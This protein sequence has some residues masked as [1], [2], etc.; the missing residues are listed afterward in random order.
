MDSHQTVDNP[1]SR[2]ETARITMPPRTRSIVKQPASASVPAGEP[3]EA[4]AERPFFIARQPIFD[5]QRVVRAYELLFRGDSD[6]GGAHF[7]DG[8]AATAQL[9][10]QASEVGTFRSLSGGRPLFLNFTRDLLVNGSATLLSA[11][12][13]VVEI[14]EDVPAD[15]NVIERC[16]ELVAA[17]YRVALDDVIDRDRIEAFQD[18]ATIVK[19]DLMGTSHEQIEA[20]VPVARH[21]RQQLLAEKVETSDDLDFTTALGF[22]YFQGYFLS[23]PESVKR[24]ALPGLKPTHLKLLDV[25]NRPELDIDEVARTVEADP[26]LTYKLLRQANAPARALNRRIT[27]MR[28]VVVLFGQSEIRRAATF[29]VM[30]AIVGGSEHLLHQSV[31]LARF[32]DNVGRA[33][34][35][36]ATESFD[37]YL[38]GLLANIDALLGESMARAL[39][40]LP[41]S[42]L[43]VA[44]LTRNEGA[45]AHALAMGRAY[46][47]G[48]WAAVTAHRDA[49]GL[50]EADVSAVYLEAIESADSAM[51]A[52][53]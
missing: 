10:S 51:A 52:A 18:A 53:A 39:R 34:D 42:P 8:S 24:A 46:L 2:T 13:Y 22:D 31:T 6:T 37:F 20:I 21:Y 33:L 17:G 28:D 7:I 41:V 1:I 15:S 16:R 44:A 32:C 49:L 19:V 29:T 40:T 4:P 26:S 27:S 3:L 43:V 36:P 5:R 47:E 35:V 45:A 25:V 12:R 23:R 50:S 14:L 48:D 30:G 11:K 38:V 9:V